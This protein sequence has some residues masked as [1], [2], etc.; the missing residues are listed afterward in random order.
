M[1]GRARFA[2]RERKTN[3]SDNKNKADGHVRFRFRS[4]KRISIGS[5][6]RPAMVNKG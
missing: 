2:A 6:C 4:K 3:G 5:F 1:A